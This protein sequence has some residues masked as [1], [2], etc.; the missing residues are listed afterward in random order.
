MASQPVSSASADCIHVTGAEAFGGRPVLGREP[1]T[2]DKANEE[3]HVVY[4]FEC[5]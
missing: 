5:R 4:S 3:V 1:L 2:S